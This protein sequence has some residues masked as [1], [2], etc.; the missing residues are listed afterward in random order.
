MADGRGPHLAKAGDRNLIA[1]LSLKLML[2]AFFIVLTTMADQGVERSDA[3]IDSVKR[4]FQ[5]LIHGGD[6]AAGAG[7]QPTVGPLEGVGPLIEKIGRIFG[8]ALPLADG[9]D[10]PGALSFR[11]DL[12]LEALLQPA[13]G[14]V[15]AEGA[16][17]LDRLGATLR[18]AEEMRG[19]YYEVEVLIKARLAGDADERRGPA[20]LSARLVR[21]LKSAGIPADR[22]VAG[23]AA[24]VPD[25][26]VRLALRFAEAP[27]ARL[28]FARSKEDPRRG[29]GAEE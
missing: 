11:L 22:L 14:T 27:P 19:L 17:L 28:D 20:R 13:D 25:A 7:G 1:L 26:Q 18:Q 29:R 16:A 5:G 10:A 15:T 12:P 6:E 21:A 9:E 3:V 24:E 4:S 2:L 8:S 23:L